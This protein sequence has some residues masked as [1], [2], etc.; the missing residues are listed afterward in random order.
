LRF[1]VVFRV[2][3]GVGV[4]SHC[5]ASGGVRMADLNLDLDSISFLDL[6]LYVL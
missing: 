1:V 6:D 3:V 4:D 2:S 5:G